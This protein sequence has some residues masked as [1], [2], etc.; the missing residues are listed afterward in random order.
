MYEHAAG[1]KASSPAYR[2]VII[3]PEVDKRLGYLESE[4]ASISGL[5]RSNWKFEDNGLRM[6]VRI[7]VN[8]DAMIH[9]PAPA[10]EQITE[11]GVAA[12]EAA[13]LQ[14]L[15]M[16]DGYA[17]FRAGSGDYDFFIRY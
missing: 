13:G 9:V 1:I 11:G 8:V 3:R 16:E 2:S 6:Q 14:F 5:I 7:P 15:S 17:V 12:Q 10:A 4:Y